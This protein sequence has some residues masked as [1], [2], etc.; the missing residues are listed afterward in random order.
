MANFGAE[1][2]D[3]SEVQFTAELLRLIPAET[4]RKYQVLPVPAST[5]VPELAE[6]P[7]KYQ[8]LSIFEMPDK[9]G[10][11]TA[12]PSD[13]NTIDHLVHFLNRPV[14]LFVTD[15]AQLKAFIERLYPKGL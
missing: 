6:S 1:H 15:K 9:V 3:L 2:I 12:D 10:I 5:V 13:L 8:I 7:R 11:A 14:E 4:A